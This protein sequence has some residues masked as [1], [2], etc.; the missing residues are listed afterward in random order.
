MATT[1]PLA[2]TA[3]RVRRSPKPAGEGSFTKGPFSEG[4][5][6]S[7]YPLLEEFTDVLT[8]PA[9]NRHHWHDRRGTGG[10]H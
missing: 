3:D 6:F 8:R 7:Y 9:S 4:M 2:M 1:V 10:F 5:K